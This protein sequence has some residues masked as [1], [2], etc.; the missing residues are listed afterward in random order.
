[1][2]GGVEPIEQSSGG[3]HERARTDGR[4]P[5]SGRVDPTDPAYER[6]IGCQLTGA[7]PTGDHD[8]L[9]ALD[10]IQPRIRHD[11]ERAG[12]AADRTLINGGEHDLGA[13][14]LAQDLVGSYR[15][16]GGEFVEKRGMTIRMG[17]PFR[18][19]LVD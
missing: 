11:R 13:R 12:V 4:R 2:A 16:Q 9:A 17:V 6:L 14:N 1:M 19:L 3:E 15:V 5:V 7:W 18:Q 8:D 10:L